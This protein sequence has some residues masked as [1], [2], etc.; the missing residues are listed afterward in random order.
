[1][2][3][4]QTVTARFVLRLGIWALGFAVMSVFDS[5]MQYV[6]LVSIDPILPIDFLPHVTL[7]YNNAAGRSKLL[8][9]PAVYQLLITRTH[10]KNT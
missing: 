10:L 2:I 9:R 1:M 3:T 6:E 7:G 4:R 5:H 8:D